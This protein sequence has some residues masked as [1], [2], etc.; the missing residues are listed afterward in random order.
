M[1]KT[2]LSAL[3]GSA[4]FLIFPPSIPFLPLQ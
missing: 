2:L 1:G 3:S 4:V